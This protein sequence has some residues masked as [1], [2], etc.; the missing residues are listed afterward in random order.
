MPYGNVAE[1]DLYLY[2]C[3]TSN[4]HCESYV[5]V[6]VERVSVMVKCVLYI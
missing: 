4:M 1:T 2:T 6:Q 3:F 5:F